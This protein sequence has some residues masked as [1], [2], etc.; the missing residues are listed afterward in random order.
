MKIKKQL[1]TE[2][3]ILSWIF[4][5][6]KKICTF[7]KKKKE[8]KWG[9]KKKDG[10]EKKDLYKWLQRRLTGAQFKGFGEDD[11][12]QRIWQRTILE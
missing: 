10:A 9:E 1:E 4:N 8:K 6:A 3:R 7:V 12:L 11:T 5:Y 2:I